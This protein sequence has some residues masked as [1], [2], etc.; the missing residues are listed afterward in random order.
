MIELTVALA[1]EMVAAVGLDDHD[2]ADLL[3]SGA[4]MDVWRSMIRAQGG[5]PDAD[6]PVA[7]ETDVI[8][9]EQDGVLQFLDAR[10]VGR[11]AARSRPRPQR[12]SRAAGPVSRC[13]PS[14]AS[15][16]ERVSR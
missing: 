12:A 13:T 14:Q 7:L 15:A 8:T 2:P 4:A 11:M 6:L 1:R 5:D 9:A 3:A 10:A 16:Y